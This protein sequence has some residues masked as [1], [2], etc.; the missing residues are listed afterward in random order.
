MGT[1]FDGLDID[2]KAAGKA[3]FRRISGILGASDHGK[4]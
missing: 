4:R 1:S 3:F 2:A